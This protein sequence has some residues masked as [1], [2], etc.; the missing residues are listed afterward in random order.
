M[1]AALA[2]YATFSIAPVLVIAIAV[3]GF[4]FGPEAAR[5][6]VV[7]QISEV[8]GKGSAETIQALVAGAYRSDLGV[9]ASVLAL[10]TLLAAATSVFAELKDSLDVIFGKKTNERSAI[11]SLVRG[12]LVA[13]G[14]IVTMG[15]L[16]LVSLIVSAALAA[17]QKA[18]GHW[19]GGIE[20]ILSVVNAVFSFVVVSALFASIYKWLPDP[21][22]AWRDA[23]VG[24]LT[25]AG[26]FT[27]GKVIIG[28]YLGSSNIA[29]GF[30]AA[31][32]LI[33]VLLWVY[34]SSQIFFM[35]AE[36]TQVFTQ[37]R[38]QLRIRPNSPHPAA[39][40]SQRTDPTRS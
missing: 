34:Y 29:S 19:L 20:G 12:R 24:A 32:S 21:R 2:F 31:G 25:T 38:N 23:V 36:L 40:V 27:L 10:V 11:R 35:G 4:V 14:L 6:E 1:G 9:W 15:F 30:G 16:L 26:L 5:G 7:A 13:V 28:V 3:A 33:A 8:T 22:I 18:W 37:Y 17:L 39:N